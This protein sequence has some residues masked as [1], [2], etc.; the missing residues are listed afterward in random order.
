MT[1][2]YRA[3]EDAHRGSR[4]EIKR[5]LKVYIPFILPLQSAYSGCKGLDIGCGRGEWL[6]TLIENGFS[7]QGV[8]L[9]AGMLA[10]CELLGL[11]A[12]QADALTF[13]KALPDDSLCVITGFHIVEHL[14][15]EVLQIIMKEAL[16][17]LKPAGLIILETPNSENIVVATENFYLDPTHERPIPKTLLKFLAEYEGFGRSKLIRLQENQDLYIE[18]RGFDLMSVLGGVSPDYAL[19]AQKSCSDEFSALFDDSFKN[20]LGI[21]LGELSNRYDQA[22]SSRFSIVDEANTSIIQRLDTL[23]NSYERLEMVLKQRDHHIQQ[24]LTSTS[25]KITRPLRLAVDL[26]KRTVRFIFRKVKFFA[27]GTGRRLVSGLTSAKVFRSVLNRLLKTN[28]KLYFLL[29]NMAQKNGL[30]RFFSGAVGT[31]Y[32]KKRN[33]F[34]NGSVSED[35]PRGAK[36]IFHKINEQMKGR[37]N[38]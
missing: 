27:G 22:I 34:S 37:E 11:P 5:R 2:F 19:I 18:G 38:R 10:E 6:E 20:N 4:E 33:N 29:K 21:S 30:L 3:F 28:P 24:L 13:L 9:D 23:A 36:N 12:I 1:G 8:D 31:S 14:P 7:A 32:A 26:S 25:W 35:L 17:V 16:R 15:F